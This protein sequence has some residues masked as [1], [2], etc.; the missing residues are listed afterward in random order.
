MVTELELNLAS[1]WHERLGELLDK[2]AGAPPDYV[3]TWDEFKT[4]AA[5][6]ILHQRSAPEVLQ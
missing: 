6:A 5:A 1:K 2:L 4:V 3:L